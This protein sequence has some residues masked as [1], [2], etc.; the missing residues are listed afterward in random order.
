MRR[1]DLSF[2]AMTLVT[3][4][5][6]FLILFP[7]TMLIYGS[8]WTDRP[9]FPGNFTLDNYITAYGDPDTYKVFLN[10]ALL[11]GAKTIC[12]GVIA[13]ALAWIIARTDTPCRGMLET[14]IIIPFFVPGIM[15][16]IGWIMLL[17]PKT[18]TLNVYLRELFGLEKSPFNIYSLWGIVWVMSLG[19]VSF[20]FIF[21]VTALRNMDAAL[22]EAAAASGAG[23]LRTA[24]TITMPMIAPIILGAS[25]FSFI[26]AMDA[27]EVPVLLGLPAKVF[28]FGNR[29]YAA[30]EYDFPVNYGL[31]T[32]LGASFFV[33]MLGLLRVQHKLLKGK[34]FFVIT[35]KGYKPQVVHLGRFKYV[36]FAFC[37]GF[38]FLATGLPLSQVVAGSFLRVF[39]MTQWDMV[40]LENYHTI[41]TDPLV[42]R[43]LTNT[44]MIGGAA[45]ILT[46]LL[47]SFVAYITTRTKYAGRNALDLICWLPNA[48]PGIVAG[49]GMLWAYILLPVPLFGTLTL[50]LIVFITIGLPVG[51][52]LMSG[53]MG[54]LS[55]ELEECS[56]VHGASWAQ[57]FRKIMLPLLKPA[58]AAGILILF[59]N[60]SRAVSTTILFSA[61]GTEL[62]AVTLFK[63][64]QVGT[65]LGLVSALAVV[66]TVINVTAMI[67]AR[68][69]GAFGR[70]SD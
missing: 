16:A 51:V 56:M 46:V 38:F 15:E 18:G 17:S 9:G 68:R 47:C 32:A 64:S 28:V 1:L 13:L 7:L 67:I 14:L 50:L 3:I 70:E 39:G 5:V 21:F 8:F 57:T 10:T 60:F 31:A 25:F 33:L 59:V 12:A 20:L 34:E 54:Q 41:V 30:I 53:V 2:L 6:A 11:I 52:R 29:I 45:A 37:I 55:P 63:Y 27:F 69:L 48:I 23:P 40:T 35:G 66:L 22:E 42:W 49:V 44:V 65:R 26:R 24:V 36:T 19:S 58:L 61:H 62:L 4:I 43:S